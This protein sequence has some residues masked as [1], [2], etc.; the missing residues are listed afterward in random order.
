[1]YNLFLHPLS[2]FPGPLSRR[3]SRLPYCYQY[4]TGVLPFDILSLH[5]K[6][7]D[8]VRVAPD[9][10]AVSHPD[11]WKDVTGYRKTGEEMSK[12][13]WFFRP[14]PGEPANIVSA[15]REEHGQLRR[16]L[17]H[18]FSEKSMRQQEPLIQKYVDVLIAKLGK[19]CDGGAASLCLSD[20]YNYTTFDIIGDLAFGEPFGCLETS[21]Y[22][23]WVKGIMNSGR[24]STMLQSLSFYP[25]FRNLLLHMIPKSLRDA[26]ETHKRLTREKMVRRMQVAK[27]RPDLIEGLLKKKDEL[28]SSALL[29][30]N[31]RWSWRHHHMLIRDGFIEPFR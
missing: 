22:H 21:A 19:Q 29:L 26:H 25:S 8:I 24:F 13:S 12:A 7:G 30:K 28:V 10:L 4:V 27:D 20:W 17:S 11:A 18:G 23:A 15:G 16:Q 2:R 3:V 31:M 1:V 14:L 5:Q 9:E 6:Y